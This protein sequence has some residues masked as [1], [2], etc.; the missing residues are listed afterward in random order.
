[1][2]CLFCGQE[3][4]RGTVSFMSMQGLGQMLL[5]FTPDEEQKKGF[6]QRKTT[7]RSVCSG[8]ETEA[9]HCKSCHKIMPVIDVH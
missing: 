8:E 4:E 5:S 9:Y 7:D 1:M 3:T 2:K 6:F